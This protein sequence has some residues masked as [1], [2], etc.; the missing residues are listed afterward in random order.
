MAAEHTYRGGGGEV[1]AHCH[2][3][4]SAVIA[5]PKTQTTPIH[6]LPAKSNSHFQ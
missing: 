3:P 5:C 6:L 2:S 1:A 4:W